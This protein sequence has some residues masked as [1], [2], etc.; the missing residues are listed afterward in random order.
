MTP[1]KLHP[2]DMR[3]CMNCV[4]TKGQAVRKLD[5]IYGLEGGESQRV[6]LCPTCDF[7]SVTTIYDLDPYGMMP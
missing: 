4:E 6:K 3:Y 5:H 2:Q 7:P 1:P